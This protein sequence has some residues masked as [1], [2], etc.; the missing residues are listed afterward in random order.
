MRCESTYVF[1]VPGY[2]ADTVQCEKNKG[3]MYQHQYVRVTW[4]DEQEDKQ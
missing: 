4:T 1:R 3:H 2:P